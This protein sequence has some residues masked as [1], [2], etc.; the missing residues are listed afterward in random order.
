MS[1]ASL[2]YVLLVLGAAALHGLLPQAA[3]RWLL[4]AVSLGFYASFNWRFLFLLLA[5]IAAA[6]LGARAVAARPEARWRFWATIGLVL[7]PLLFYKYLLAWVDALRA[8]VIPVSTLDFG[9]YGEVLIPVGLSF[10]TFQCLGYVIDVARGQYKPERDPA[11]F[12]LF[13]A[14]FPILLSG[15]IERYPALSKQLAAG[16]RPTPDMVLDGL[17]AI[18]FGLF[19]KT[20]VGDALG[21]FVDSIFAEPKQNAALTAWAGIACFTLQLYADFCGYSLIAIGAGRLLGV[22]LTVNF[23]QP[24]FVRSIVDFWQR[25]HISLTRWIGDYIYRPLALRLIRLKS[26]PRRGQEII[27]LLVTWE[28]MGLWHGANWTF[29]VFGLC[30]AALVYAAIATGRLRRGKPGRAMALAGW[31]A[32]MVAVA[33]TF[34]LIRA[35][36]VRDYLDLLGAGFSGASGFLK[37][38]DWE[39]VLVGLGVLLAV[40]AFNR[41]KPQWRLHSVTWR[42]VLIGVLAMATL[43]LGHEQSRAFIYFRF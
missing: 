27:V 4:L 5:V 28:T 6:F 21:S 18:A 29:I 23:R 24:F 11:A 41:L 25:W 8:A 43:L 10:F 3:R 39:T 1:V 35:D 12:A 16:A 34:G 7:A 17:L 42:T 31:A 19:M 20:V 22:N 32:T 15:P 30:Q 37:P 2:P 36:S 9:G 38:P 40:D 26:I 33:L 14:F 13:V